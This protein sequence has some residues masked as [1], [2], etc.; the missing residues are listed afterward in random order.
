MS[1][2]K[3]RDTRLLGLTIAL[4]LAL[5]LWW[6]DPMA[7]APRRV[8]N[9]DPPGPAAGAPAPDYFL[10][11]P[12]KLARALPPPMAADCTKQ[13]ELACHEGDVF[14]FDSCG[15]PEE[16]FE[17]CAQ[18]GCEDARCVEVVE[19]QIDCGRV[20]A[21]GEC[22]GSVAQA[23]IAGRLMR[24]DCAT[25][26][27]RCVMTSE[28]ATCLPLDEKYGCRDDERASCD[29][30]KLKLCV[31]GL[32]RTIDCAAR[33]ARCVENGTVAQCM[34]DP[35][36]LL[37]PLADVNGELCNSKD[38][39]ADG[40][41]DEGDVCAEVPL[42]AFVPKGAELV[43]HAQR[44]QED[45]AIMN[46]VFAPT[47]FRWERTREAP[48]TYKSFDPALMEE[49]ATNLSQQESAYRPGRVDV[50]DDPATRGL[51]FYIPVLYTEELKMRPP[52]AGMSTLPNAHCGGVRLSDRPSPVS[53]LIVVSEARQPET[54]AHEMGHYLGLCHTH[55]E[56]GSF[57]VAGEAAL[58]CQLSG[59]SVCDTPSDPGPPSCYQAEP[60]LLMC[61]D[62]S[63]PDP[64]NIMSYYMGCRRVLTPEQLSVTARNLQLRRGWF[65]CQDQR[66]CQCSPALQAA[67]P[68]EMS[69]RPSAA[70]GDAA[71]YCELD[72]AHLPGTLCEDSAEC[73]NRA[74]CA[75][76]AQSGNRCIR[77][78]SEE[79]NCSCLDVGLPIGV[80]REDLN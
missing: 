49:A 13:A 62:A 76:S 10:A 79:P 1:G 22:S 17:D 16:R 41:I 56:L 21:Y 71:W 15:Q 31:D 60:C 61:R 57:V 14:W 58:E 48:L 67:C 34:V 73:S 12:A 65:R 52:K 68:Q 44:M 78:C 18:R 39:D 32:Y 7:N 51:N 11:P 8:P 19:E 23:C 33:R 2:M 42:V 5:L 54:L 45:L 24:V 26:K 30:N 77:P 80:C 29:G 3:R 20:S 46:R 35:G 50:S 9:V 53:G 64:F 6:W 70:G 40:V 75:G 69:C 25:Y 43:N 37:P 74:F 66:A 28:G 36:F 55:E 27:Q 4:G 47:R 63:R 59:D 38:D 72:G